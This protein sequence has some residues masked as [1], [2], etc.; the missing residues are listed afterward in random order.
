MKKR[1]YDFSGEALEQRQ[2][3]SKSHGIHAFVSRGDDSLRPKDV[4]RLA[5][6]R[7]MVKSDAGRMDLREELLSRM[8]LIVELGYFHLEQEA[9]AGKDIWATDVIKR[10]G[11]YAA[12][13]RRLLDS[14]PQQG[15][16]VIAELV[17]IEDVINEHT[18]KDNRGKAI[19]GPGE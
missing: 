3:A 1:G 7:K 6:L 17:R 9:Q 18:H 8:F 10:M 14:W 11:T 12:E 13:C 19:S 5:E 15:P 16:P 2:A 4:S